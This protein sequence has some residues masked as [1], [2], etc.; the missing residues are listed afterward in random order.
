M[1]IEK[2]ICEDFIGTILNIIGKTKDTEKARLDLKD[3]GIREEL[4]LREDGESCK[5][6][7]ARYILSKEKCKSFCE[8]L[9]EVKFPDGFAS[10]ISRCVSAD[11][12]KLQGPK[13]H[14]YHI[15]LQRILFLKPNYLCLLHANFAMAYMY[16]DFCRR[17]ANRLKK[18]EK[19]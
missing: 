5:K 10:N 19:M 15:L 2:N 9:S 3:L 18:I 8:F 4:Q 7:N 14:D 13:T 1:H 12:T 16:C 17:H 6:P 11:G